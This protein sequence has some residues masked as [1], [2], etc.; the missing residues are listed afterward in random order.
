MLDL[1]ADLEVLVDSGMSSEHD[2]VY[3]R[4]IGGLLLALLEIRWPER[5]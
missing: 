1:V 4:M 3:M 5:D 2:T